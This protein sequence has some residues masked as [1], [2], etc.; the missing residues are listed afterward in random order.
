[1]T[2][3]IRLLL[4]T[5]VLHAGG[6]S[7]TKKTTAPLPAT[8]T[9]AATVR[10]SARVAGGPPVPTKFRKPTVPASLVADSI[11]VEK[12]KRTLTLYHLG[13]P[14]RTYLVALGAHPIGPKVQ[15]GDGRT[16]EGLY[17]IEAH[18]PDSKYHLSLKI[19]YP[20][21]SDI[22]AANARGVSTGGDI[23]IHGLP[24]AF[25]DYGAK[26]RQWDWT[27]G[28]IAVTNEEIEEIWSAVGDG[29]AIQIKP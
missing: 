8:N 12:S 10:S 17:H 29:A 19:S 21:A 22:A 23:M 6:D 7:V 2:L 1:M 27:L 13:S 9:T 20:S 15:Q 14:V 3:P 5:A 16:P 11:V 25:A 18:N 26:H 28:C 24:P 4:A